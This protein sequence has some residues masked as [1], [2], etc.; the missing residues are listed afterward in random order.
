MPTCCFSVFIV[1]RV[2]KIKTSKQ[3]HKSFYIKKAY[4]GRCR[5]DLGPSP[6]SARAKGGQQCRPGHICWADG[7]RG[8]DILSNIIQYQYNTKHW[9]TFNAT[10]PLM[11]IFTLIKHSRSA[12]G[13]APQGTGLWRQIWNRFYESSQA[14]PTYRSYFD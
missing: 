9:F 8:G 10:S 6:G 11:C 7:V 3:M 12:G 2:C 14:M 5:R 4:I 1:E 13:G